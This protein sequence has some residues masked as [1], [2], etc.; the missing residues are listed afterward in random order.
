MSQKL[1]AASVFVLLACSAV[2]AQTR[3]EVYPYGGGYFPLSDS[4]NFGRFRNAGIVGVKGGVVIP[5]NW[6]FGGNFGYLNH[7]EIRP[8]T[9]FWQPV[10][11]ENRS[12]VRGLIVEVSGD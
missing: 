10:A 11:P 8:G 3:Y 12:P 4:S 5:S 1:V 6:E 7:F 9:G 2:F